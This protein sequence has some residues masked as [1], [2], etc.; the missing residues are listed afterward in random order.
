MTGSAS[1]A[2]GPE[3]P[4]SVRGAGR[5]GLTRAAVGCIAQ[6]LSRSLV[7]PRAPLSPVRASSQYTDDV[8]LDE[9][10]E[11][12]ERA[13]ES[14]KAQASPDLATLEMTVPNELEAL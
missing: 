10:A 12:L 11:A 6:S 14:R 1:G 3:G 9:L 8:E 7:W 4:C 2:Q 5:W 13:A